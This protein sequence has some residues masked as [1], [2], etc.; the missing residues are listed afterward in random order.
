VTLLVWWYALTGIHVN[1]CV[2]MGYKVS[3]KMN[4]CIRISIEQHITK[5]H[6]LDSFMPSD[7]LK[8]RYTHVSSE[9]HFS[10]SSCNMERYMNQNWDRPTFKWQILIITS[11]HHS[12]LLQVHKSLEYSGLSLTMSINI[13]TTIQQ[14]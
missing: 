9:E 1:T 4:P 13:N 8:D 2:S 11:I 5:C 10:D 7:L 3:L 12:L 14:T 6:F